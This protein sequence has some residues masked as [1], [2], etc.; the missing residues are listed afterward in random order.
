[1]LKSSEENKD[2]LKVLVE[3]FNV[4]KLIFEKFKGLWD[5][6]RLAYQGGGKARVA[7]AKT[8]QEATGIDF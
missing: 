6:T 4:G 5:N 1:M 2:N 8:V 3:K 7:E